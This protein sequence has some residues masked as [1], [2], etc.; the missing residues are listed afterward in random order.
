[1]K[2]RPLFKIPFVFLFLILLVNA[3]Y[4][5]MG[6]ISICFPFF[7]LL[8]LLMAGM[9]A[10]GRSPLVGFDISISKPPAEI[11]STSYKFKSFT[12]G[13]FDTV[14][15]LRDQIG[16][17][18][19]LTRGFGWVANK[20]AQ[21]GAKVVSKATGGKYGAKTAKEGVKTLKTMAD[22]GL[23]YAVTKG[24]RGGGYE[25]R[26]EREQK[27]KEEEVKSLRQQLGYAA[28]QTVNL[29]AA[30][31]R[32][33]DLEATAKRRKLKS[34]ERKELNDLKKLVAA[35]EEIRSM[36]KEVAGLRLK[37]L[38]GEKL[39]K[40]EQKRLVSLRTALGK[41]EAK[42]GKGT[43]RKAE[44]NRLAARMGEADRKAKVLGKLVEQVDQY[45]KYLADVGGVQGR[46]KMMAYAPVAAASLTYLAAR[47][48]FASG[49]KVAE[50]KRVKNQLDKLENLRNK[51]KNAPWELTKKDKALLNKLSAKEGELRKRY[52][53][54]SERGF[55]ARV[56]NPERRSKREILKAVGKGW[57]ISS[58][59]GLGSSLLQNVPLRVG[60]VQYQRARYKPDL[61]ARVAT[62]EQRRQL[63]ENN[64][65]LLQD[66]NLTPTQRA[67]LLKDT[68]GHQ[69]R[70][71][72]EMLGWRLTRLSHPKEWK[73]I[74]AE[75]KKTNALRKEVDELRKKGPSDEL[76][77]KTKQLEEQVSKLNKLLLSSHIALGAAKGKERAEKVAGAEQKIR[78]IRKKMDEI[79]RE[80][81]KLKKG[82]KEGKITR[83]EY[84]KNNKTLEKEQRKLEK[85][86][87]GMPAYRRLKIAYE[88]RTIA[89]YTGPAQDRRS[90]VALEYLLDQ[91]HSKAEESR[92]RYTPEALAVRGIGFAASGILK[93]QQL[94][95][96]ASQFEN[97]IGPTFALI[98]REEIKKKHFLRLLGKEQEETE[99]RFGKLKGWFSKG[100][101]ASLYKKKSDLEEE[102]ARL[103][104]ELE[105]LKKGT[106]E[107]KAKEKELKAKREA[108]RATNL[109]I[110]DAKNEVAK[111]QRNIDM[112]TRTFMV[113]EALRA[114]RE[115]E[116][117]E[118][119]ADEV[120]REIQFKINK[121]DKE[122][123]KDY[124][125]RESIEKVMKQ[126]EAEGKQDSGKYKGLESKLRSLESSIKKKEEKKTELANATA[127]RY[128]KLERALEEATAMTEIRV[129]GEKILK[130][131]NAVLSEVTML[132]ANTLEK[133][134]PYV[135]GLIKSFRV[136]KGEDLQKYNKSFEDWTKEDKVKYEKALR[137]TYAKLKQ[138]WD[139]LETIN[140]AELVRN[141][142]R[143]V[144]SAI[145]G[146][147]TGLYRQQIELQAMMQKM[148]DEEKNS[149]FGQYLNK[150]NRA[151]I[152]M[153]YLSN[154]EYGWVIDAGTMNKY[155]KLYHEIEELR[156]SNPE[157]LKHE[158]KL[159]DV[160]L[161]SVEGE[162]EEAKKL[163]WKEQA[164]RLGEYRKELLANKEDLLKRKEELDKRLAEP[165][166][167]DYAKLKQRELEMKEKKFERIALV[168]Q[169]AEYLQLEGKMGGLMQEESKKLLENLRKD[170]PEDT[171]R[172]RKFW[173]EARELAGQMDKRV[174]ESALAKYEA[175]AVKLR[176][177][178]KS[179]SSEIDNTKKQ[180]S[181]KLDAKTREELERELNKKIE[182]RKDKQ[183]ELADTCKEWKYFKDAYEAVYAPYGRSEKWLGPGSEE[184]IQQFIEDYAEKDI[185][186]RLGFWRRVPERFAG[187]VS[188]AY[189]T[190]SKFTTEHGAAT[191]FA[192]TVAAPFAMPFIGVGGA[193][194]LT[195][196]AYGIYAT[197]T[198]W[199]KTGEWKVSG[200][201]FSSGDEQI[202]RTMNKIVEWSANLTA[203]GSG[204]PAKT[205]ETVWESQVYG[206]AAIWKGLRLDRYWDIRPD[207]QRAAMPDVGLPPHIRFVK[208]IFEGPSTQVSYL[209]RRF[210]IA[211]EWPGGW[212]DLRRVIAE[213]PRVPAEFQKT[214]QYQML[215]M[216]GSP[217]PLPY[218]KQVREMLG[219]GDMST[220]VAFYEPAKDIVPVR[221]FWPS[222]AGAKYQPDYTIPRGYMLSN[223]AWNRRQEA[224]LYYRPLRRSTRW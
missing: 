37:Q 86:L 79:K 200:R 91:L 188:K 32:I 24:R 159:I 51:Q 76:K 172:G 151:V 27:K 92:G 94:R 148:K 87:K 10:Q 137:M 142:M 11:K 56:F 170:Y 52:A 71:V 164:E 120:Q 209:S 89:P 34:G 177:E 49:A 64:L 182:E 39:T 1:M 38:R 117:F 219:L 169:A 81:E 30:K 197:K 98:S 184:R 77:A 83:E 54:L 119:G 21:G 127:L 138:K 26:V 144:G 132:K 147:E 17:G 65:K 5:S 84:S 175:T 129:G 33:S 211:A 28:A 179:L 171:R 75:M 174:T 8:A 158:L 180:L 189:E 157:S 4:A 106:A 90:S 29:A 204:A 72:S 110:R 67:R 196:G 220:T 139:K 100:E 187:G 57:F 218:P 154:L 153:L 192:A 193:V 186:N 191:L 62:A 135:V 93:T 198:G 185:R 176:G 214:I 46:I 156:K 173:E 123:Q 97:V 107:Y 69:K 55:L 212:D 13:G 43:V 66:P 114:Y 47:Y 152:N 7:L 208:A 16:G 136:E 63:I 25:G 133:P 48:P 210:A 58:T 224:E 149:E 101:G 80:R 125:R 105:K 42:Y 161:G 222:P 96:M 82:F 23:L 36:K 215:Q 109:V 103:Q 6:D 102:C 202:L 19:Y 41:L 61:Q 99:S 115:K 141:R 70:L 194:A 195:G 85:E 199:R 44:L 126:L 163:G 143:E 14:A 22:R 128:Q 88:A 162:I 3:S 223:Q 167:K 35:R 130:D 213:N 121:I 160:R 146:G 53:A 145:A 95:H 112:L 183:K 131:R 12:S 181:G 104:A 206:T 50:R 201:P 205:M 166:G 78:D 40:D 113:A 178:I 18:N 124:Q 122:L 190:V 134:N 168:H 60:Q 74:R 31:K 155:T 15:K 203:R 111:A 221:R 140:L 118:R 108:L 9:I 2:E 59:T 20:I 165:G 73:A 207:Q 45:R 216:Y 150:K 116:A 217:V 68:M